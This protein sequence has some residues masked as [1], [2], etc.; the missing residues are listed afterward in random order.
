MGVVSEAERPEGTERPGRYQRS[1]GG[2][3]AA[4]VVTA[5]AVVGA[6]AFMGLFREETDVEPE[7]VDYLEIVRAVQAAD[8]RPVYPAEIPEGWIATKAELLHDGSPDLD[9]GFLT[10]DDEY[11][12]VVWA[13]EDVEDLLSERVDDS[14]VEATEEFSVAGSVA[15]RWQ[16]Y[17][18]GGGDH[19][20]AAEVG[21]RTVM[22][23]GSGPEDDFA[24]VV[25]ALTTA[26]IPR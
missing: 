14:D 4:L 13:D 22:V 23:Y 19:A 15:E 6:V 10:D 18:D 3:V 26:R 17:E 11:I 25:G 5:V 12:G 9:L 2:L 7:A 8:L 21:G 16:G 20:Y 1:T 24:A